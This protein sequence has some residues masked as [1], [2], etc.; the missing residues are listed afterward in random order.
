MLIANQ[1]K[2]LFKYKNSFK[3]FFKFFLR[4]PIS[5]TTDRHLLK[6][7]DRARSHFHHTN[8]HVNDNQSDS[9]LGTTSSSATILTESD[10]DVISSFETDDF[11]N[12]ELNFNDDKDQELFCLSFENIL[13]ETILELRQKR[14]TMIPNMNILTEENETIQITR[15]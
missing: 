15:L 2:I 9:G 8:L 14:K 13:M 11:N 12:S 6:I 4:F 10:F 5:P 3:S 7:F 1:S